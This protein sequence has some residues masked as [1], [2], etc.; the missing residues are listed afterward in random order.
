MLLCHPSENLR[1]LVPEVILNLQPPHLKP[2]SAASTAATAFDQMDQPPTS[3][4]LFHHHHHHPTAVI[5]SGTEYRQN[6][7]RSP[8]NHLVSLLSRPT[9]VFI[10]ETHNLDKLRYS[11]KRNLRISTCRIYS[12]QSLNWL[13]R[14]VTQTSS[15]H[16]LMWWFVGSLKPP[17]TAAAE[18]PAAAA[19][20]D[21]NAPISMA[22]AA[23]PFNYH[24]KYDDQHS[25]QSL[26]HP[27]TSIKMCGKI[28]L[29]LSQSFHKFLQ[30]VAD[31]T[32][33]LPAGSALQ[34]IAIQ[35]FGIRFRPADHQFLHQSHV[36][37]NIS[38]ILSRSDEQNEDLTASAA[39]GLLLESAAANNVQQC[40]SETTR[41]SCMCDLHG[42]FELTVSSRQAMI[43]SL[44][45]GSTET[46]WE[47]DEEDRNRSKFIDISMTKLTHSCRL[48][49]VHIDNSRDI[50]NK[51]ATIMF[52]GGG[53]S[54]AG[55]ASGSGD[56]TTNLRT[57]ELDASAPGTWISAAVPDETF[58]HFRLELRGNENTLRVRQVKLLGVPVQVLG[59]GGADELPALRQYHNSSRMTNAI[60]I[61]QRSCEAE[62][63]R[64]FR[65]IT[66]QVFGKLILG[67][68]GASGDYPNMANSSLCVASTTSGQSIGSAGG[69]GG[70]GAGSGT[71][72][73]SNLLADSLDLREHMV[74]L[75][76]F[77]YFIYLDNNNLSSPGWYS[78]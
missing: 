17:A 2:N 51:V 57:V 1:K 25:E 58:T 67:V 10:L 30:S 45:D 75:F 41:V 9:M 6:E 47:S 39:A 21:D 36:F 13:M 38:K 29:L 52:Y 77:I 22:V 26:D 64:V 72:V 11:L 34:Q 8:E 28:S 73:G 48:I 60:Q 23:A 37:G 16:D 12:L 44:T 56:N 71:E 40:Q 19:S 59:G 74:Y 69:G 5:A 78:V 70:G 7:N 49:F 54:L 46:F 35:C 15:L 20:V 55:G 68:G 76:Y 63:L 24:P 42:M 4:S 33:L 62:T 18:I 53:Q 66:A 3:Y 61:Q 14:S 27:V 50:Q 43:A 32:L 31:L 65:L